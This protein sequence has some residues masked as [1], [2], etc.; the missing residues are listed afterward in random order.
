MVLYILLFESLL[1][2]LNTV[3]SPLS[4]RC[5]NVKCKESVNTYTINWWHVIKFQK[6]VKFWVIIDCCKKPAICATRNNR[7]SNTLLRKKNYFKA[8]YWLIWMAFEV[9][10]EYGRC[11]KSVCVSGVSIHACFSFKI[12]LW[13]FPSSSLSSSLSQHRLIFNDKDLADTTAT[14]CLIQPYFV[15]IRENIFEHLLINLSTFV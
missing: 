13:C 8:P 3:S 12:V 4:V 1:Y 9:F 2:T 14:I 11:M 10:I 7:I 15:S 6:V 5:L